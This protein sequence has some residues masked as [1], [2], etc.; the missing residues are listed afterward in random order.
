MP[1]HVTKVN[2]VS[3]DEETGEVV[4]ETVGGGPLVYTALL[5][6][7]GTDAPVYFSTD[8]NGDPNP[9]E[10]T[11]GFIPTII[12]MGVGWYKIRNVG[13]FP[14]TKTHVSI[15][16]FDVS[17][18]QVFSIYKPLS[19]NNDIIIITGAFDSGTYTQQNSILGQTQTASIKIEV[20]P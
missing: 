8:S 6:Q 19:D 12:Y 16:G 7:E 2:G 13:G 17:T 11:L 4:I 14:A 18:G 9:S 3:P 15:S 20:Y 1:T 5:Q 10:N